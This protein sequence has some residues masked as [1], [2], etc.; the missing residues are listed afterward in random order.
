M[1]DQ[2]EL[3]A[4]IDG[5]E[6]AKAE[7][8]NEIKVLNGRLRYKQYEQKALQPFLEQTKDVE[9]GSI[10]KETNAL[11]FKIATQAFTPK[12]EREWV[13]R[14]KKLEAELAKVREVEHARHKN[15]LVE[16]DIKETQGQITRIDQK[17][18]TVRDE[19]KQLYDEAHLYSLA[20]K[21]GITLG[22]PDEDFATLGDIGVIESKRKKN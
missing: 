22:A 21:K 11:E 7:L 3:K 8:I 13:K 9:V 19:L 12:H 1:M 10:R 17:L 14:L 18:K 4:K 2:E 20:N 6:K 5:L 16:R 15:R